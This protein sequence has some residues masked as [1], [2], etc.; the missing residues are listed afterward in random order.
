MKIFCQKI[1]LN[2]KY[3]ENRIIFLFCGQKYTIDSPYDWNKLR[4][5]SHLTFTVYDDENVIGT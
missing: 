2:E 1:N 5:E 3:L 4:Y